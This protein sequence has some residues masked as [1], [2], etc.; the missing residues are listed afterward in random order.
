MRST[1]GTKESWQA[2]E[3]AFRA[4][5]DALTMVDLADV[6]VKN[7]QFRDAEEDAERNMLVNAGEHA[8]EEMEIQRIEE[9][10]EEEAMVDKVR[11]GVPVG[12]GVGVGVVFYMEHLYI[13]Y[14]VSSKIMTD[15]LIHVLFSLLLINLRKR[16]I[17]VQRR[18]MW[19][20]VN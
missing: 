3:A 8:K 11:V 1:L 7:A 9:E 18:R 2:T 20:S 12:V 10:A 15:S 4:R 14:F 6:A 16:R 19:R 17:A 13:V 5:H